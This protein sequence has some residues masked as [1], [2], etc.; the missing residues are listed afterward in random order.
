[1]SGLSDYNKNGTASVRLSEARLFSDLNLKMPIHPGKKDI[2]P[3]TDIDAIKQ[4]VRNLILTNRG[5]KPFRNDIGGDVTGLLFENFSTYTAID[6]KLQ[7]EEVLTKYE[8]RITNVTCQVTE[9]ADAN[10]I[11]VTIGF[12]INNIE[13]EIDLEFALNRLR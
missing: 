4:S 10:S 13:R 7:V 6:I 8:P 1:M 3:I 2:I 5:E 12:K 9:M 11:A